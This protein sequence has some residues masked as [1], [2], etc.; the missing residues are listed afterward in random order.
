VRRVAFAVVLFWV[1]AAVCFAATPE[2]YR[3]IWEVR[4]PTLVRDLNH[5]RLN[6]DLYAG[7]YFELYGRVAGRV[8]SGKDF[9]MLLELDNKQTAHINVKCFTR[10]ME[11]GAGV[12]AVMWVPGDNPDRLELRGL[13]L[14]AEMGDWRP[15]AGSITYAAR[16]APTVSRGG[17][18]WRAARGAPG[19]GKAVEQAYGQAIRYFNPRL[20]DEDSLYIA[21][22]VIAFSISWGVDP[23]LLMAVVAVESGFKPMA[24]S[25]K[26]AMG[27]GQLMPATARAL[28]VEN[29]YD[30]IQNLAGSVKLIRG[31][32]ERSSG[33]LAEALARYNAGP[34]AVQRYGG[35][36]PYRET[37]NY[38][39]KVSQLFLL[40]APEYAG[41]GQR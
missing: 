12:R 6:R 11:V 41:A 33:D 22:A 36:P 39:R 10:Q 20:S 40:F 2:E 3:Q 23:R 32:L 18:G 5:F 34:G 15:A 31:H 38:I 13:C 26:G 9:F 24:T 7:E 37:V 8:G 28:G 19:E 35:V 16:A 25:R 17:G 30:P 29:A 4:R 21:R 27:L 14:V 1:G